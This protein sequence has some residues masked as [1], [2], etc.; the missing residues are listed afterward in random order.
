MNMIRR[1]S[2]SILITILFLVITGHSSAQEDSLRKQAVQEMRSEI[3]S[4]S[5]ILQ[6]FVKELDSLQA[7]L[8]AADTLRMYMESPDVNYRLGDQKV[9]IFRLSGFEMDD[10]TAIAKYINFRSKLSS[11]GFY[12]MQY[13]NEQKLIFAG[14]WSLK[15]YQSDVVEFDSQGIPNAVWRIKE[16]TFLREELE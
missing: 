1:D 7:A 14:Q 13:D 3:D 2:V 6:D 8:T 12:L 4:L 5:F 9:V 10:T 11:R 16:D 15:G